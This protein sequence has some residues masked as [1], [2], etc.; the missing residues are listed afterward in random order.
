MLDLT[1]PIQTRA[2]HKVRILESNLK[3]SSRPLVVAVDMGAAEV[4]YLYP[5]DGKSS[6]PDTLD[7]INVK[8][9]K[10]TWV[11]TNGYEYSVTKLLSEEEATKHFSD[12][13]VPSSRRLGRI[14]ET[15]VEE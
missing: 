11:Y 3:G 5:P 2:G 13:H 10:W 15:E 1:K 7:L 6:R 14:L 4:V 8:V 9:K 12:R